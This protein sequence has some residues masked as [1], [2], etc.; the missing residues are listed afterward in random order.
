MNLLVLGATGGTGLQVV[1]QALAGGHVVTALVRTPSKLTVRD[2]RLGVVEGSV[3]DG[4]AVAQVLP[5]QDAVISTLGRGSSLKSDHLLEHAVPILLSRMQAAGVRRLI[6]TSAIGVGAA[7]AEAPLFSRLLIRFLL[8]DLYADK[9]IAEDLI[10]RSDLDWTIVQP[11][12]LTNGPLTR[13]YRSGEHL[14]QTGMPKIAK[15][16]VADF[17]LKQLDDRTGVRKIIRLAY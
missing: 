4:D 8:K 12:Q 9:V 16:D 2:S 6:F 10:R 3:I 1:S 13:R 17:L 7:Y 14:R 11:A 5:G 15:A